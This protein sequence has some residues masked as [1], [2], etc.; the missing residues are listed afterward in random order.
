VGPFVDRFERKVAGYVGARFGI[1]TSSGTAALHVAL[2]VAG[3]QADDEVL[4]PTV[5][6][7]A[8]ANAVR[9]L[10]AWPVFMDVEPSYWQ[11]DT[12]KV[13]DFVENH[14]TWRHGALHNN[15]TGRRVKALLPV[16]VLGHP[17]DMAPL[18]ALARKYELAVI[19]DAAESLGAK[20]LGQKVGHLGDIA[21]CSFNGNKVIT[22]GGGGMI[23]TDNPLWAARAKYLT[24]QAKDDPVEY[25]HHEIG[26][27]YR[28]TNLQ[29]AVGLAQMEQVDEYIEVK[30]NLAHR[31]TSA[32]RDTPEFETMRED[33]RA[34]STFWLYTI[35]LAKAGWDRRELHAHL[36]AR[37]I[38]SRPLWQPIHLS[39]AYQNCQAFR[40]EH[41]ERIHAQ[42][43]SLPSSVE[44]TPQTQDRVIEAVL[45]YRR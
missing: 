7:I 40:I 38:E 45:G 23:V 42:A 27:N 12:D 4:M 28:L 2:M 19:E 20:Y 31:Y 44:L 32:F 11:M 36:A 8:P 41:A 43:L 26:Y 34:F 33:P 35:L 39:K 17:V 3:V 5:T 15:S 10:Q 22:A 13:V 18:L 6:F 21:C 37:K 30:R 16:H 14:C 24:T 1:A 25:I 29:A 9:Y